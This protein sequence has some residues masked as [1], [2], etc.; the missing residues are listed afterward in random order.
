MHTEWQKTQTCYQ[1]LRN[2]C[3]PCLRPGS[4]PPEPY[5]KLEA[6]LT[7]DAPRSLPESKFPYRPTKV[8]VRVT[9]VVPDSDRYCFLTTPKP[10]GY[11]LFSFTNYFQTTGN[12]K[13]RQ[14][15]NSTRLINGS[16]FNFGSLR[17]TYGNKK[18]NQPV[19]PG[20]ID[21]SK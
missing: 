7:N 16:L 21:L 1:N 6:T 20:C 11:A 19:L 4:T 9:F 17:A 12:G 13:F 2:I 18:P 5:I 14:Q 3:E 10:G 15:P 8:D